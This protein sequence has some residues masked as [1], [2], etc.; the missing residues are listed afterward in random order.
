MC[1][2]FVL[3]CDLGFFSFE[4]CPRNHF[5]FARISLTGGVY[6]E[7]LFIFDQPFLIV[8][9]FFHLRPPFKIVTRFYSSDS[10][11]YLWPTFLI[12]TRFYSSDSTF[13][14]WPTFKIVTRF[15][16]IDSTFYLWPS[17]KIVTRF[18]F[19]CLDFLFVT[20]LFDCD[21]VLFSWQI[22]N[23]SH[24]CELKLGQTFL[25]TIRKVIEENDFPDTNELT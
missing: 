19:K 25:I 3:I 11:F 13:Y 22:S 12:V 15:F 21:P 4:F 1:K 16:S 20:D 8:T 14:L 17:F 2:I 7:F 23:V 24:E 9:R 10:T 5:P 18:F 6:S